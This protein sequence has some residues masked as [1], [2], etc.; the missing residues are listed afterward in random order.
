MFW[1]WRPG[2]GGA[3]TNADVRSDRI[4]RREPTFSDFDPAD[5]LW[6][7]DLKTVEPTR[8]K[9]NAETEPAKA[10]DAYRGPYPLLNTTL[11]LVAGRELALQDRKADS[12]VLTPDFCGSKATGYA[13]LPSHD[14]EKSLQNKGHLTL[15]R[16]MTI[17]GAAVDPNM[18]AGQSPPLTALMTV[19]NTRLGW[20][21]QNPAHWGDRW[22]GSGPKVGSLVIRE[23]FGQTNAESK[24][25]HL[26][27]GGHFENLGVYEPIRRRCRF[28]IVADVT[29]D[30]HAASDN[31]GN[32]LRL[33]RTDFG[34]SIDLDTGA[35]AEGADCSTRWH[36]ADGRRSPGGRC[37][38]YHFR[39]SRI[40]SDRGRVRRAAER[41]DL[42][43]P[44]RVGGSSG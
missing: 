34:I 36:C 25:I 30:R 9:E 26:S 21:M 44:R 7:Q 35:L 17:S 2:D 1:L 39:Q 22:E 33:I 27:D 10:N 13:R 19:L 5:D 41:T 8:P 40:R 43:G 20:W 11:N 28:I 38:L 23:L 3:P 31:L 6:L 18:G 29:P 4:A 14:E 24:Y 15:G 32:L 12:F 16:A 42:D 37:R